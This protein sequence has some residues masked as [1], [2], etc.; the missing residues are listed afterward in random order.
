MSPPK[1]R[2]T[3]VSFRVTEAEKKKLNSI[4]EILKTNKSDF[5]RRKVKT[6]LKVI[7]YDTNN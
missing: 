5:F 2:T 7:N 6:L 4:I 3:T 1:E